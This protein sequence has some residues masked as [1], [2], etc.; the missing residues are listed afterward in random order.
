MF[1]ITLQKNQNCNIPILKL[2]GYL[3]ISVYSIFERNLSRVLLK[4]SNKVVLDF[5]NIHF[6]DYYIIRL[7]REYNKVASYSE[8]YIHF[9]NLSGY[10]ILNLSEYNENKLDLVDVNKSDNSYFIN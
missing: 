3:D 7:L 8:G 5:K 9:L 10:N 4:N 6:I 2:E 1:K